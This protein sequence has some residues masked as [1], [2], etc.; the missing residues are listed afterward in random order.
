M[1][2]K[3]LLYLICFSLFFSLSGFAQ[4]EKEESKL[5]K[6]KSPKKAAIMAALLPSAG[7]IYNGNKLW[8]LPIIYGGF[9]ALTYSIVFNHGWYVDTR[10]AFNSW[11]GNPVTIQDQTFT[12]E[13]Q[14]KSFKDYYRRNR[15]L[16]YFAIA[17]LYALQI[18]DA[19]IDAHLLSFTVDEKKVISWSPSLLDSRQKPTFGLS[20]KMNFK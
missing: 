12:A 17:G 5:V 20:L 8:K 14:L 9:G 10:D 3:R 11:N 16:S 13:S 18:L 7:H 19:N 1:I 4:Q 6:K 2:V 15:D